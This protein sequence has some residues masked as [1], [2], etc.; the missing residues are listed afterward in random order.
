MPS[1]AAPPEAPAPAGTSPEERQLRD[2]VDAYF[3]YAWLGRYDL[4]GQFGQKI[5]DEASDPA[6]LIPVLES[7]A[8]LHDQTMGYMAQLLLFDNQPAIK[9]VTDKILLKVQA[10]H[11]I[12]AQDP[13]LIAQTI[14]DM[15]INERAYENHLPEL[16]D[17]GEL[18]IPV[19]IQFLQNPDDNH[20][21]YRGTVR[22]AMVDL[23]KVGLNP[24]LAATEMKDY[25]TLL[26]VIDTLGSLGYDIAAPYLTRLADDNSLPNEVRTAASSAIGRL[27]LR[28]GTPGDPPDLYY[29]LAL[30]F[31]YRQTQ[32]GQ[33]INHPG[34]SPA[35]PIQMCN[36]W[37][38]DADKGL[39]YTEV[40]A[41]IFNDLMTMRTLETALTMRAD[42]PQAV[43][44]WLDA[45]NQ[46][47]VDLPAGDTDPI[48]GSEPS[49]HYFNVSSGA[50]HL[51]DALARALKDRNSPVAFKLARSLGLIVGTSSMS[52]N[53]GGPLTDALRY[54]DKRVRYEAACALAGGLP[55]KSFPNAEL[56][57]P[58]LVQAIGEGGQGN[59]LVLANSQDDANALVATLQKAGYVAAGAG[60]PGDAIAA[61]QSMPSVD[62]IVFARG[63]TDDAIG[64]MISMA[65]R[66]PILEGS[67]QVVMKDSD[68]G[69][70][71]NLALSN[72]LLTITTDTDGDK[73]KA[74]IDAA[75]TKAGLAPLDPQQA[76]AYALRAAGD[77]ENLAVAQ[78]TVLPASAGQTGLLGA[79]G[80]SKADL[81]C[82]VGK[83]LSHLPSAEA[84]QA[85][86]QHALDD[87]TPQPVRLSLF[88]SLTASAQSFGNELDP[89]QVSL[90]NQEAVQLQDADLRSA[91]A[92]ARGSLNLPTDQATA[93]ILS[94]GTSAQ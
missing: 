72:N 76:D 48:C 2:D 8:S 42:M 41:E 52:L 82:L 13:A 54:P 11:L 67:V 75:R 53:L 36:Y 9:D 32:I 65:S 59:V 71:A 19:M 92:E 45:D 26:T 25:G 1:A 83:V 73:L 16:R 88:Q 27:Q 85:L 30:R 24:L 57:V 29:D 7:I 56:V 46:R 3:H 91:A 4:A 69:P 90:L 5:V 33:V 66:T 47:E 61:A 81:V 23:G 79:L 55:S 84:Q 39:I 58:L 63:T 34:A 31:Y 17:S 44:L 12:R 35:T 15:S 64:Q 93:L 78:S 86:A 50:R 43:A 62:A 87:Q 10:G 18:A 60:S 80:G 22:R 14:R 28:P 51:D 70:I 21:P 49:A 94:H 89:S 6:A 37:T 68:T 74:A 77:L 38:Y 40:P 20:K